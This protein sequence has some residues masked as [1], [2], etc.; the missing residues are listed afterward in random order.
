MTI[1]NLFLLSKESRHK[2]GKL[3]SVFLFLS[4]AAGIVAG[5]SVVLVGQPTFILVAIV[6]LIVFVGAVVSVE[7]GLIILVV[8]AYT[9]LSDIAVHRFDALSIAKLI[10]PLLVVAILVRWV[11]NRDS[12]HGWERAAVL[13]GVYGMVGF[14]SLLYAPAPSRVWSAIIVYAKDAIIAL[15]V[16]VL[17]QSPKTFKKV[18]WTL[19]FVGIFLGT[20]SIIQYATKTYSNDYWGFAN[21]NVQSIVG[22]SNDYRSA[23]P[24]GD[25]NYYAQIM[26]VL[27]P[28]SLE[29]FLHERR[30][31]LRG[32]ALWALVATVFAVFL[33]Y[34]R[35]GFLAMGV[36]VAAFLFLY[37]PR[38]SLIPIAIVFVLILGALAPPS[39]FDR[40]F[41]LNQLFNPTGTLLVSDLALRGRVSENLA[42]F[43]MLKS[44][45]LFGVGLSNFSLLFNQYSKAAG[46]ALVATERAAHNL[47]L[48]VVAETGLVGLTAFL[49]LLA[50]CIHLLIIAWRTFRRTKFREYAGLTAG[51]AVGFLGYLVAAFF[52]HAAFPRYFYLLVGIALSFESIIHTHLRDLQGTVANESAGSRSTATISSPQTSI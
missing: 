15:V 31:I 3:F 23:G 24:I 5:V 29:R 9:R 50:N 19:L 48:E 30:I 10:I 11:L 52:I 7:F 14:G 20:L 33:T 26:V 41:S 32:V 22:G 13:L 4:I 8:L 27:V 25:P 28:M 1:R 35:G 38:V 45:P 43:E 51:F 21:A 6:G 2:P 47:Y 49:V 36:A 37:P 16:V 34:S 39:Y 44:H 12:P 17:L 18:V 46:L 42:A 40:I